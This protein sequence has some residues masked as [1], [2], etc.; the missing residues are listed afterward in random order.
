MTPE[1]EKKI[2]QAMQN[3][4]FASIVR[5]MTLADDRKLGIIYHFV[6]SQSY[7]KNDITAVHWRSITS[8]KMV[9]HIIGSGYR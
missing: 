8:G 6:L 5:M 7:I 9:R 1:M 2:A 4:T 3:P